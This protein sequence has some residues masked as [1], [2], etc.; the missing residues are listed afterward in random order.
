MTAQIIL[1]TDMDTDCDDAGAL[2]LLHSLAASGHAKILGVVADVD[3]P[4]AAACVKA[5]NMACGCPEIPVGISN[6]ESNASS[7]YM[8]H[9][10][11]TLAQGRIYNETV[12]RMGGI[13]PEENFFPEDGVALYRRLL[14][15]SEDGSVTICAIGLLSVLADLLRSGPCDHSLLSGERLVQAKVKK[16]VT[17][18][19]ADYP[20]G[21]DEFNWRMNR[22]AASTV[23]NHW[24][25]PV[26]V[27]KLGDQVLTGAAMSRYLAKENPLVAA[28]RIFGQDD[29][30]FQR[31]SWDQITVLASAGGHHGMLTEVSG[32]SLIYSAETGRHEWFIGTESR[33]S[34]IVSN[35]CDSVLAEHIEQLMI[36]PFI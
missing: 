6:T 5:I 1:D 21:T 20:S 28:Y 4:W 12:A 16:L 31:P 7:V 11:Q 13:V 2:V 15:E 27:N 34:Y 24:P 14:A 22:H 33:C 36:K 35:V 23:I 32:G 9:Y 17:M 26:T 3:N 19:K 25:T 8:E 29:P 10:R 30:Q 18:A